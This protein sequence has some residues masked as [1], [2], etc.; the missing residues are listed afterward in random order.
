MRKIALILLLIYLTI[1]GVSAQPVTAPEGEVQPV[2]TAAPTAEPAPVVTVAPVPTVAPVATTAP[3]AAAVSTPASSP[4]PSPTP[5]EMPES[6]TSITVLFTS[7]IHGHFQR[8]AAN[9]TL[10]YSGIAAIQ[11]S[12][13]N[14][15]LVDGGDYLTSNMFMTEETIADVLSLMNAAGYRVAGIGE[16]D[17][18]NG[19]EILQKAQTEAGFYMLSSNVTYGKERYPLLGNTEICDVNGIKVGFFS[20]LNPDLRLDASLQNLESV[21]LEDAARTAQ[22]CVNQLKS[23][24]ADVVIALSHIG[25][26]GNTNVDQIAAFVNGIDFILD[27]HDHQEENGR[28]IGETLILNPGADGKQLIQLTLNYDR[29]RKLTGFSTTQWSY[30]GTDALPMDEA[31]VALENEIVQK[32][33]DF[34]GSDVA[35]AEY[36]IPYSFS[37]M[38]QSEALGNFVA[39][40]Y[41]EKT[42]ATVAI[43]NAGSIESGIP[44]GEITKATILAA[45]PNQYSVQVKIVTP[46]M[47][48]TA[49]EGCLYNIK[50]REDG[51][52][53]PATATTEFPQISGF[54]AQ[55][56]FNN[57][58]GKRVMG[59]QLDNG[60][61]LNLTDTYTQISLA[62][63]SGVFSGEFGYDIFLDREV[64]KD[65]GAEGQALLEHL[66]RTQNP[67]E[68][69]SP[70]ITIT[71]QQESYTGLII[72][73]LL[74]IVLVVMVM[75][76]IIKM[77]TRDS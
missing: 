25:N 75:I 18:E 45:L 16:A 65:Y 8:N 37:M 62:S 54:T 52:V 51:S 41:R 26:E 17:L 58:P 34:L 30:E 71:N 21:Y 43:V 66:G 63:S 53:D 48:K 59:I 74:V 76:A 20:I 57:E 32:Q 38:Y 42:Q 15:I 5:F 6:G 31:V 70:R 77:M 69:Q 13:P 72:S 28:W 14:S 55:V 22:K 46:K 61:E 64:E 50:V 19:A 10:G 68:Y 39:D 3:V 35:V 7:D 29:Y 56:N 60:I 47:L 67:E 2:V 36:A 73:I 23:E 4:T 49:L 24:G 9:G 33:S 12:L 44:Q 11:R 40:A 27:G 1:L